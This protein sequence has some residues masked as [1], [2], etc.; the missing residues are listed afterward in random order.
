[1]DDVIVIDTL[2][3]IY[4]DKHVFEIFEIKIGVNRIHDNYNDFL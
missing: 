2:Y 3:H 1:M 4:F